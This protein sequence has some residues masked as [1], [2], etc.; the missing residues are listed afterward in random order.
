MVIFGG[1]IC[2]AGVFIM[3]LPTEWFLAAANSGIGQ[4]LGHA[5]LGVKGTIHPYYI[6]AAL[7]LIV[8]SIGEAFYSPRVYE[9]AAAIAPPGQ[10][11]SYGSL[12]Y[13]PFL[14]G[15]L[16][17]GTGGWL[18]AAFCPEHGPRHSGT[19]WLIFALAASIAPIGLI[20][21]RPYIRVPEEGREQRS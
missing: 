8:F 17:V 3:A 2:T 5:Y 12:A 9:Y 14:V 13:L 1:V 11:A 10:E 16:L 6:M 20:V 15:K 7:Y 19:M 18:L 21:F 4:W